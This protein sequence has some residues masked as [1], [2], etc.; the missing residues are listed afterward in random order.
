MAESIKT[1]LTD[2]P[3]LKFKSIPNIKYKEPYYSLE[4]VGHFENNI[5]KVVPFSV[6][7]NLGSNL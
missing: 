4:I 5:P 3:N 7:A 2:H 6:G 1:I